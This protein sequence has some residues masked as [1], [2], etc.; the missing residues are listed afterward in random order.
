MEGFHLPTHYRDYALLFEKDEFDKLPARKP[1][2]HAIDL[3]PGMENNKRLKG[4]IYPLSSR[5][6]K[7]LDDWLEEELQTGKIRPS[8][9]PYG[10]PFFFVKK[11]DGSLRPIM[12]YRKLNDTTIRN[13]YPLLL[14]TDVL[15]RIKKSKIFT[16]LD[17]QWGYNNVRIK[18]GDEHKAT[19]ITNRG[20][21]E[22]LVMYFGLTN[23]PATFQDLMNRIFEDLI[24][25]D[26]T[27]VI[28]DDI[29][30]CTES[31]EEHQQIVKEVL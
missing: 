2:D 17:I 9:S 21:F 16:K 3:K 11:K 7:A 10:A 26:V 14:I 15:S 27:I 19:F 30:I 5:E 28:M 8:Q 25:K 22:P 13:S 23:S 6:Q 18:E 20:L 12:D 29:L 24:T 31:L 1:W 4:K